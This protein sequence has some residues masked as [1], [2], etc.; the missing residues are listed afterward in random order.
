[1]ITLRNATAEDEP[2]IAN[3]LGAAYGA[4]ARFKYPDRWRWNFL[5]NPFVPEGRVP[6]LIAEDDETGEI[7]G[8][9]CAM[10][11]PLQTGDGIMPMAW[12][13]DTF[14]LP[15]YRGHQAGFRLQRMNHELNPV[16]AA[17]NMST[18]NRRIKA[19]SGSRPMG[20]LPIFVRPVRLSGAR[21]NRY[22]TNRVP[23]RFPRIRRA[24]ET[25][26]DHS[27]LDVAIA[28]AGNWWVGLRQGIAHT[29]TP[30]AGL[31][32]EHVRDFGREV[33]SFWEC[34][35]REFPY[36]VARRARYLNWKFVQQPHVRHVILVLRRNGEMSGYVVLRI[37]EPPEPRLGIISDLLAHPS[38]REGLLSLVAAAVRYFEDEQVEY[39]KAS[40]S[41]PAYAGAL[42]ALGFAQVG[43]FHPMLQFKATPGSGD[44]H[45]VRN[46]L[47]SLGDHDWDQYPLSK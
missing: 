46:W 18:K 37:G 34:I 23:A 14:V 11:V 30:V 17:L 32:L 19:G 31:S 2:R 38:D 3:F 13:V 10:Y 26:L 29:T 21:M 6:I 42:R 43:V 9:S 45:D 7:V 39:I 5:D 27:A 28:T 16:F 15:A 1:M 12:A 41:I 24:V 47:L 36:A 35:G 33:D 25:L 40:T 20:E 22:L 4:R 44:A 8:Q